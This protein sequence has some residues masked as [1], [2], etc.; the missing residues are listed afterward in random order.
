MDRSHNGEHEIAYI[1]DILS[2]L[3]EAARILPSPLMGK[4]SGGGE[5]DEVSFR[6]SQYH[7]N[8]FM[9]W[10]VC[11]MDMRRVGE[12]ALERILDALKERRSNE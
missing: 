9:L 2:P 8:N 6:N 4:G 5:T 12:G 3:G 1:A 10:V 11:E 7:V